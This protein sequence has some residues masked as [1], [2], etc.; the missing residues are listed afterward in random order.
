[1]TLPREALLEALDGT[2][3]AALP[4]DLLTPGEAAA[5]L[6]TDRRWIYKHAQRKMR[7]T[8]GLIEQLIRAWQYPLVSVSPSP[9]TIF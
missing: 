8:Y 7:G 1:M 3:T 2:G 6:K 5:L 4:D 9:H